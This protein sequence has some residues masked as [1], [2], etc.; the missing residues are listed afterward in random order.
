MTLSSLLLISQALLVL[1]SS[2]FTIFQI[3]VKTKMRHQ[4][5]QPHET[6][7]QGLLWAKIKHDE[8]RFLKILTFEEELPYGAVLKLALWLSTLFSAV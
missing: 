8:V 5:S 3:S 4:K 7:A 2:Y 1:G 6:L